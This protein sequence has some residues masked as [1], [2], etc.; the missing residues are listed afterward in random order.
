MVL[1]TKNCTVYHEDMISEGGTTRLL[2]EQ[3]MCVLSFICFK[4]SSEFGS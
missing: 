4:I 2:L 1:R 3:V